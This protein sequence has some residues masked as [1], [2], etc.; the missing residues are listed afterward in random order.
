MTIMERAETEVL[1][2]AADRVEA[3]TDHLHMVQRDLAA[4]MDELRL[5]WPEQ[6]AGAFIAAYARFDREL[7]DVKRGL[8]EIHEVLAL[9]DARGA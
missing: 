8:D 9:R 1:R 2:T 6:A 4:H 3:A 5:S 7:E